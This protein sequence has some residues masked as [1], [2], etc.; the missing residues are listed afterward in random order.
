MEKNM[1]LVMIDE[2]GD[3]VEVE[4]F[5]LSDLLD[6]DEVE[7]WKS[8]KIAKAHEQYPEARWFYFEDRRGWGARI[9]HMLANPW[10]DMSWD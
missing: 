1:I 9:A 5:Y 7:I 8:V 6:E 4:R 10:E 3:E 2:C